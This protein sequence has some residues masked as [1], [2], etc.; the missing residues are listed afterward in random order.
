VLHL[1]K[2]ERTKG[3]WMDGKDPQTSDLLQVPQAGPFV[4]SLLVVQLTGGYTATFGVWVGVHPD[5]L[6][7]AF[8]AWSSDEAY[9]GLTIEGRLANKLPG[10][11]LLGAPVRSVVE[12]VKELPRI[13]E[14]SDP[15]LSEVLTTEWPHEEVLV[16]L[17]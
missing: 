5:D 17:P 10:W 8:A 12:D 3:T 2:Q 6:Q 9:R 4:R 11:G 14:S 15:A 16:R 13:V 7:R 1:R